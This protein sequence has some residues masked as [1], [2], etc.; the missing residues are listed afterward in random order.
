MYEKYQTKAQCYV[1]YLF[2]SLY[3][4]MEIHMR[5]LLIYKV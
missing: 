4:V 1:K 3:K 2:I 5:L